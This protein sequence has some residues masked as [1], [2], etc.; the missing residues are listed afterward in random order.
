MQKI[1]FASTN[2][3]K[4]EEIQSLLPE[5]KVMGLKDV[6]NEEIDIVEDGLTFQENALIKARY[7]YNEKNI[8]VIADDSGFVVDGLDGKPGVESARFMGKDT[9][10]KIKNKAII[11]LVKGKVKTCRYVCAIAYIDS[12]GNETII[13]RTMEGLVHDKLEGENGFGYDPIFFYEPLSMTVAAMTKEQ[14]NACSHRSMAVKEL[15]ELLE[16]R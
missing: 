8:A 9:D 14:K 5:F 16:K 1:I 7:V 2:P 3:G 4:I 12:Q 11:D 6:F 15:L 13:E 10:Y